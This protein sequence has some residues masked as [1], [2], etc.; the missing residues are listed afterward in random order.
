[1]KQIK[2]LKQVDA[3]HSAFFFVWNQLCA[4]FFALSL[5]L[6]R[7]R[8]KENFALSLLFSSHP[9]PPRNYPELLMIISEYIRLSRIA[10]PHP[11]NWKERKRMANVISWQLCT[12]VADCLLATNIVWTRLAWL[13]P[14]HPANGPIVC[15]QI[16]PGKCVLLHVSA[17]FSF[18]SMLI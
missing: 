10:R 15:D 12:K 14:G 11:N 4:F 13:C 17:K 8:Q 9:P 6:L 2:T 16:F 7:Q 5:A 18:I 3:F 1:M